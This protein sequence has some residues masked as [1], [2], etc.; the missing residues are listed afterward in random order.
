MHSNLYLHALYLPVHLPT[1]LLRSSTPAFRHPLGFSDSL[2]PITYLPIDRSQLTNRFGMLF[3]TE[4]VPRTIMEEVLM[5][6]KSAGIGIW[7]GMDSA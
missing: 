7:K 3:D 1:R 5:I 6:A 2:Q 4:A